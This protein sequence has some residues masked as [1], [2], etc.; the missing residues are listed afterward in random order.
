MSFDLEIFAKD[1]LSPYNDIRKAAE[2]KF[3]LFFENMTLNDLDSLLNHLINSNNEDTKIFICVIIR[4]F[5]SEKI[6][7]SNNELFIKYFSQNKIKFIEILLYKETTIRLIKNILVCFFDALSIL[8]MNESL[9]IDNILDI[10]SFFSQ[11]YSNQKNSNEIKDIN[12]CLFIF[13]KFIKFIS[14]F[15]VNQ[16]LENAIKNFYSNIINDYKMNIAN[17]INGNLNKEIFILSLESAIYFLKL[18]KHSN[19]LVDDSYSDI[20]LNNT[21]ELNVYM[22]NQLI[23]NSVVNDNEISK[24]IFD[25][26]FLSN[27]IIIIY[28]SQVSTLSI[29]TLQK[30][31][32]IFY[33]YVKEENIFI[34]INNILQNSKNISENM[35][36]KFLFDIINFFYELLQLCSIQE[37]TELQIFGKG[38]TENA[39][40]ISDFFRNKYWD[41]EKIKN[42]LL[43]I[44]KNYFALKSKEIMMGQN[45]PEE[46]YLLFYN[47]DSNH[48]DLRGIA[49]KVCRIIY[50]IFG[51][52]IKDIYLSF[53]NELF[54][55][56][57][58]EYELL[59]KNQYLND[60]Q[61]NL[62]LSLLLYYYHVDTHFSSK[63]IDKQKWLEQILLSQIDPNII[64]KKNEIFS[65]FF[66]IYILTKINSYI[67]DSKNKYII[68][69]KIMELFINKNFNN[70]LLNFSC[71]DYIFDYV[72]EE[73]NNI[74]LPKNIINNY[75]IKICQVLEEVTSPDI[76]NKILETTNNLLKKTIDD[77]LSLIFPEIFPT[78][79]NIWENNSNNINN[80]YNNGNKLIL[81]RSNLIK[82]IEL[83]VKKIGFFISYD[84]TENNIINNNIINQNFYD[85]YFNF[86]YQM[87]GYSIDVKIPYCD[88]LCKSALNLIIF[89][90]D[91]FF[92]NSSLAL[93]SNI[94]DLHN[95]L[96]SSFYFNYFIKTYQYLDILLSNLSTSNQYFILQFEAIEQFISFSFEKEISNILENINFV[97]K[98]IYIFNYFIKNF[99][100]QY[101]MYI[102]NTIEYIYYIILSQSKVNEE[103]KKKLNDYIYQIIQNFFGDNNFENK[104]NNLLEKYEKNL[105]D[106]Y[107]SKDDDIYLINIYIGII[108]LT[109]RYIFINASNYK[110][111][112]ND[113]N[114]FLAKKIISLNKF[115]TTKNYVF[116]II[117]KNIL[118]NTVFNLKLLFNENID[119]NLNEALNEIYK[120]I[121]KSNYISKS[122]KILSHW[123][124]FF[125]KIYNDYYC[126]KLDGE[127]ET[128]K[129]HWKK[130][131]EKDVQ[132][133][134]TVNKDYKIKYLMIASDPM[135]ENEK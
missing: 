2:T 17:I 133:I 127:E 48:Y 98:I 3:N 97:D 24:I 40:E 102:F 55:L 57:K 70:F 8:K 130:Y 41:K 134:D 19:T 28:I 65:T 113:L 50:D 23:S 62:K 11:Y 69:L 125:N 104:I 25:I 124:Y 63:K 79:K 122:D 56:T 44:L 135:Y 110:F 92:N 119:K 99:M 14:K 31:A 49:G 5:I 106:I 7:E 82:L 66:I 54:S 90:Q 118:R 10:F 21:Y 101:N 129:Y 81:I 43:F 20:I 52:E 86:I 26:I 121:S 112:N 72:E 83:F 85:N 32:D 117:Q 45:E 1:M 111:I 59:N 18:F 91:D 37:F 116:N 84:D 131:I 64:I 27:K 96:N 73:E 77:E 109:N 38:F 4:K 61:L 132:L 95:P 33:I 13:K 105:D 67:L 16:K 46:F 89:I 71:I 120:N 88:Y 123:L 58:L 6:N 75:V 30:F 128:L 87:L 114:I 42:L 107:F 93:Y 15:I 29:Q 60:N 68:F 35:E 94:N 39:I 53:E 78:L 51:K 76:H 74:E 22:L 115:L 34:Y 126:S 103:F 80:N 36:N 9:C 108:Q 47:S 12:R 100:N